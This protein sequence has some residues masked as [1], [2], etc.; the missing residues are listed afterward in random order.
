MQEKTVMVFGTFDLLHQGHLDF[1]KQAKKFGK[2]LIV[3][4]ARDETVEKVKGKFPDNDE[5]NRVEE[6]KKSGLAEMVLLGNK[7]ADKYW[8]IKKYQPDVICLGYDQ[9]FFI[10]NLR[11]ELDKNG[12]EKT[13]IIRL[14]SYYPEKYKSSILKNR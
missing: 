14:K 9:E 11:E 2:N 10:H 4:V 3:V 8:L 13:E 12:L 5:D 1:F 6:I 7:G